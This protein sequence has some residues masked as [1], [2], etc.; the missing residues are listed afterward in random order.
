MRN[1]YN[2]CLFS[3]H[4]DADSFQTR[5]TDELQMLRDWSYQRGAKMLR[6]ILGQRVNT[7]RPIDHIVIGSGMGGMTAAAMLSKLARRCWSLSSTTFQVVTPIRSSERSISGCRRTR[8]GK[9]NEHS[10]DFRP[11]LKYPDPMTVSNGASRSLRRV[12]F[13]G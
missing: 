7:A 1:S 3:R 10:A 9:G 12:L 13:P 6:K 8:S 2:R 11:P 4:L 5:M